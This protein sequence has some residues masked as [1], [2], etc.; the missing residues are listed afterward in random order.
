ML[1]TVLLATSM[2]ISAPVFAQDM[3]A[4]APSTPTQEGPAT[5]APA[6]PATDD[7]APDATDAPETATAAPQAT[8]APNAQT[9]QPTPAQ[10]ADAAQPQTMP[11][12]PAPAES[13]SA[14]PAPAAQPAASQDQVAQAVGRD[15][16]TYDKDADGMLNAIEFTAWMGSLRKAAEPNFAPDSPEGKSWAT[17]AFT[18]ADADKNASV[19]KQELT[20]FLTPKAS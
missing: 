3:P 12:Q 18:S 7:A 8:P 1:K 10:A 16:G 14:Q 5:T 11:T 15:F 20:A 13:A 19:N 9:A 17:Q 4:T 2:L 6:A